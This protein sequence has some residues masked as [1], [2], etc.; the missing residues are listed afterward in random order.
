MTFTEKSYWLTTRPYEPGPPLRED[1]A[2]DVVVI[3]GGFT[4]LSSAYFIRQADPSLRVALIEAEVIGYGASGRNGGFSMTKIGMLNSLTARRFGRQ[5]AIEAHHYAD[6][7]VTL[8]HDLV[9]EL[10]LDCDYEHPGLLTVATSPMHARRLERELTLAGKL[11]LPGIFTID[12][13]ELAKRVDSPIYVGGAWWEPNCGILN[14]AKLA[15]AWRDVVR[16]A[17]VEVYEGTPVSSVTRTPAGTDVTTPFGRVRAGKV[18]FATNAWSHRFAPLRTKQ[19]PVWTYIVLTEPLPPAQLDAIRWGGREGI[20]DF[21]DLV[22]Y[23]RLTAD[24][25]IVFGGRDVGLWDGASMLRD[26]DETIFGKLREDL[27]T[28]FPPL[29]DVGFTHAW[30]GPVSVT[31]DLFPALGY[32]GGRDWVYSLGCVGHGVSTTHLN[33]QTI[34]DLVLERDTELT[35]TFF[36]NRRVPMFP[37]GPLRGPVTRGIAG[38]MRWED[39]RLDVLPG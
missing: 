4:G 5:R 36:V 15:W 23:Y 17:G 14:P 2:A 11:G 16:A 31:I 10:E 9:T 28:T 19:V 39:R 27:R 22:H 20:E 13:D 24:N 3:G 18:V 37:P 35:D 6:R 8:V 21:R 38:F 25:R 7:A 32:A 33:G 1:V 34:R 30:G 26:R 29:R 12:A